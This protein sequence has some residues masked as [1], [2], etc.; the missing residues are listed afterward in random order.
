MTEGRQR[1]GLEFADR[2]GWWAQMR[3]ARGGT[4]G[5]RALSSTLTVT[6]A[7]ARCNSRFATRAIAQQHVR[8]LFIRHRCRADLSP[9]NHPLQ[10]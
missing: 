2:A 1:C 10:A 9:I 8:N 5:H 3:F 4:H 7:C 6:N